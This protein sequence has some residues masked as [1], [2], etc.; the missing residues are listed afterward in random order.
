MVRGLG[1][2]RV[3][4]KTMAYQNLNSGNRRINGL[5]SSLDFVGSAGPSS[6]DIKNTVTLT[7]HMIHNT[8]THTHTHPFLQRIPAAAILQQS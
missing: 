8:H 3:K 5:N 1:R 2:E 4:R 7:V 6:A